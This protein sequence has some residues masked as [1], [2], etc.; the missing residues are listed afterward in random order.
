M[1]SS[2]TVLPASSAIRNSPLSSRA[3]KSADSSGELAK[4][5]RSTRTQSTSAGSP[6]AVESIPK[7][8]FFQGFGKV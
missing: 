5:E 8:L 6:R 4:S 3:W 1:R 2:S 7:F